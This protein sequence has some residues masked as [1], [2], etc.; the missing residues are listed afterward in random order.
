MASQLIT[1]L[2]LMS[3]VI[4][5][6]G[7]VLRRLSQPH[8]VGYILAGV[9]LGPEVL[10]VFKNTETITGL[11]ELGVVLLMFFVGAE[12]DLPSLARNFARPLT[13]ALSQL[14]FSFGFVYLLGL[15]LGWDARLIVFAFLY[16]EPQQFSYSIPVF[17]QDRADAIAPGPFVLWGITDP[18][19]FGCAYAP[20][21]QYDIGTGDP[22]RATF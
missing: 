10:N 20:C 3:L 7:F 19:R 1:G 14:F 18:G 5:M 22:D 17:I 13:A 8:F 9:L 6:L 21:A 16:F 12:I 11:G 2:A 15:Y 4:L